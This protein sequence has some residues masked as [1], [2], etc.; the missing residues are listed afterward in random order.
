MTPGKLINVDFTPEEKKLVARSKAIGILS[1]AE[2][3]NL[4]KGRHQG[5]AVLIGARLSEVLPMV[6]EL[7]DVIRIEEALDDLTASV[8]RGGRN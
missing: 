2:L 5:S 3:L 8:R 6:S 7:T 1:K 4:R